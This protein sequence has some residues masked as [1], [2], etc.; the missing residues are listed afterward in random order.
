VRDLLGNQ[1]YLGKLPVFVK[2]RS[3]RVPE[4]QDGLH[5]PVIDE[6][7]FAAARQAMQGRSAGAKTRQDASIYSLSGLLRCVHCGERMRVVRTQQGRVRY[8]CRSKTQGLGR[9]GGGSFLDVYEQQII[10]DLACFTLPP[11]WQ[12]FVLDEATRMQD[13]QGDTEQQRRQLRERLERLKQLYAWGDLTRLVP[14][15]HRTNHLGR[16][17]AYVTSLPAAWGDANQEQRNQ[18][19][20]IIYEAVWVDGPRVEY[21]KPQSELEPLFQL[22]TGAAQPTRQALGSGVTPVAHGDP[23]G[24]RSPRLPSLSAGR[25]RSHS[26]R[27]ATAPPDGTRAARRAT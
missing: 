4:R 1:F 26:I 24:H 13:T 17:A 23:D 9:V 3:R 11:E 27:C 5:P 25:T 18:L 16:L 10:D 15:E 2:G 20:S 22:R 14:V 12:Q 6:A 7:F 19:A 8:L 21:V